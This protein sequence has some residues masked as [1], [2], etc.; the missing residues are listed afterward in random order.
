[1]GNTDSHS[2]RSDDS[3]PDSIHIL[4]VDWSA[5]LMLSKALAL[6][7]QNQ[8]FTQIVAVAKGGLIPGVIISNLL[9][10]PL[11]VIK[12]KRKS[13]EHCS[14][15][16]MQY[17][18]TY[19][20]YAY[21]LVVDDIIDEGETMAS[22]ASMLRSQE[23]RFQTVS[24]LYKKHSTYKPRYYVQDVPNKSLVIFPWED[25]FKEKKRLEEWNERHSK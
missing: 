15:S 2:L 24:M 23:A 5:V 14:L 7:A 22:I 16:L 12:A 13:S 19:P 18:V 25:E 17:W 8:N 6:W 20:E 3:M 21:L 4:R 1:M 9:D 11:D 10:L